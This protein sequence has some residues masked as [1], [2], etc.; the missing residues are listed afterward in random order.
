MTKFI[1]I[2]FFLLIIILLIIFMMTINYLHPIF[3]LL[4]IMLYS[5]II[6]LIMSIWSHNFMYSIMLFLIMISGMLIMFLYFSSLISNDQTKFIINF[7]LM[8]SFFFNIII[9]LF[10]TKYFI[11]Y[12]M[13]NFNEMYMSTILNDNLFNNIIHIFSYPYSNITMI[14]ILYLLLTLFTIIK[15]CSTKSSTLRKLN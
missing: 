9:L 5:S 8:L 7:P 4:L 10:M 6:C 14:C 3:M 15:I 11:I 1:H 12:P 13:Y 2:Q